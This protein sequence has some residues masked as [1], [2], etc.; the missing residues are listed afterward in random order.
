MAREVFAETGVR[1][2]NLNFYKSQPWAFSD[3][4]LMG[5]FCELDGDAGPH[6]DGEEL[7]FADWMTRDK[8][9]AMQDEVAL[10]AEMMDL[11][12]RIGRD[13]LK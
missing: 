11:F 8:V 9:P 6:P 3:S 7:G 5:F 10:T 12:K 4:L 13:V 1:V 2:K